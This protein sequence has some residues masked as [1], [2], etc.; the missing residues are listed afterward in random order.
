M[1]YRF[2][3]KGVFYIDSLQGCDQVAVS[4][5]AFLLPQYRGKNIGKTF[6]VTRVETML[7]LG[8]NMGIATVDLKNQAQLRT[9]DGRWEHVSSFESS[10]TGNNV[11]VFLIK[12]T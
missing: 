9:M 1:R 11:G 2:E 6:G 5:G 12:L 4:H 10:K 7:S 3:D 8:Y